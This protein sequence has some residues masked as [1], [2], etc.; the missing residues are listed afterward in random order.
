MFM[1]VAHLIG[2]AENMPYY[3]LSPARWVCSASMLRRK[4]FLKHPRA[5]VDSRARRKRAV[6]MRIDGLL[7]C[8][9]DLKMFP[10]EPKRLSTGISKWGHAVQAPGVD[11]VESVQLGPTSPII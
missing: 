8:G 4:M 3:I 5:A 11:G 1:G 7:V 10:K 9:P 2:H 6:L